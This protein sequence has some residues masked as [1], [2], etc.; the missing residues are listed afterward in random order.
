MTDNSPTL[1]P[2]TPPETRAKLADLDRSL[3]A[4]WWQRNR[5]GTGQWVE[6]PSPEDRKANYY[7]VIALLRDGSW[8]GIDFPRGGGRLGNKGG[9]RP[10]GVKNSKP[11]SDKGKKNKS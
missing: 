8:V 11:R 4:S 1:P 6:I 5:N 3:V 2:T 9:G 10:L 7:K